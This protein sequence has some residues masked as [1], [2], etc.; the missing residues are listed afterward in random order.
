MVSWHKSYRIEKGIDLFPEGKVP[1]E[2]N[3]NF[4]EYLSSIKQKTAVE[5][6]EE[7]IQ[8]YLNVHY[9]GKSLKDISY[10]KQIIRKPSSIIPSILPVGFSQRTTTSAVVPEDYRQWVIFG[11]SNSIF[12]EVIMNDVKLYLAE[13]SGRRLCLDFIPASDADA[14]II[15]NYGNISKTPDKAAQIKPVLKLDG[16][17]IVQGKS[18]YTGET[19]FFGNIL[20]GKVCKAGTYVQ[21]TC[22]PVSASEITIQKAKEELKNISTDVIL[23]DSIREEYLGR[24]G[25]ILT[26]T[27]LLREYEIAKR[28]TEL[29]HCEP[30]YGSPS[31]A[32]IYI[33]SDYEKIDTEAKF[34]L[35]PNWTLDVYCNDSS[36]RKLENGI[37][38][39]NDNSNFTIGTFFYK[40]YMHDTSWNEGC[41]FEDWQDTPGAST[42]KGIMIAKEQGIPV[43]TLTKNDIV[44]GHLSILENETQ[45]RLDDSSIQTIIRELNNDRT[46]TVPIRKIRYEDMVFS[47]YRYVGYIGGWAMMFYQDHGGANSGLVPLNNSTTPLT[48]NIPL[49]QTTQIVNNAGDANNPKTNDQAAVKPVDGDPV[50]LVT[51]EFYHEENPDF[52]IKSRGGL[53]LDIIRN[54]KSQLIYNGP[55]G[56]GWAWNHSERLLIGTNGD[57]IF[58]NAERIPYYL[59]ANPD[60]TYQ[61]P[62]GTTFVMKKEAGGYVLTEKDKRKIFFSEKG[63]LI[64]KEDPNGNSLTFEYDSQDQLIKI[65]DPAD[66]Y[67]S[68]QYN[69]SG[70]ISQISDFRGGSCFYDY[71]GDDLIRFTDLEGNSYSYEYLKSQESTPDR[72]L[73]SC[74]GANGS[75]NFIDK[76]GHSVIANGNAKIDTSQS[77]FGGSSVRFDGSGDYLS[78]SDSDDWDFG[79]GDFTIDCWVRPTSVTAGDFLIGNA[80]YSERSDGWLIGTDGGVGDGGRIAFYAMYS[81]GWKVSCIGVHGMS[82]NTWHH[83]AVVRNGTSVKIYVDGIQKANSIDNPV[84]SITKTSGNLQIGQSPSGNAYA[85]NGW[86]DEFRITKG[87]ARWTAPFTPPT[88]QDSFSLNQQI[89]EENPD[90]G[91]NLCKYIL[92]NGD[93][94]EIGYYKNDTVSFHRNKKGEVFNFQYSRLNGYAETWNE[95]GY[96]RKVFYNENHDVTRVTTR[97]KTVE[98]KTY[99]SQHNITSFT[100][101]N[102]WTTNFTYDANRNLTSKTNALGE[103]WRYEYH[104]V[105]NKPAKIIDP[106]D[107]Q[108]QFEYDSCGNLIKITDALGN[109]TT[110]TYD[111]Y[112][113]LI[114]L[115]D[116]KGF[117]QENIYDSLGLNL[118][119]AKDK[120]A[121]RATY[122]YDDAGNLIAETD[123]AYNTTAYEYNRYNQK[124]KITDALDNVTKFEYDSNRF[125]TKIIE[126]NYAVTQ[127]IY[128]TVRDMVTGAKI[129]KTIDPL[130]YEELY[131]YDKLGNIISKTDKN[132]NTTYFAYDEMNRLIETTDPFQN[133]LR[134]TYDGN[135]NLVSITD[136][137]ENTTTFTYDAANR[138]TSVIDPNENKTGF[139]YDKSGN[140]TKETNAL[141]VVTKYEYDKLNRLT[142]KI[143]GEGLSNAR[144]FSFEYNELGRLI[145][146]TDPLGNWTSFEYDPNGNKTKETVYDSAANKLS[147]TAYFYDSRSLLIKKIDPLGNIWQFEYD[148]L[149]RKTAEI[150]P[151]ENRI[152]YAYDKAGN[153]RAVKDQLENITAFSYNLRK[154]KITQT[155]ALGNTKQFYYDFNGNLISVTDEQGNTILYSYDSL[156]RKIAETDALDNT[157]TIDYDENS[158][159][160]RKTDA[161]G[162]SYRYEYDKNNLLVTKFYPLEYGTIF[163]YD[164]LNRLIK[165]FDSRGIPTFSE[166]DSFGQVIKITQAAGCFFEQATTNFEYDANGNKIKEINALGAVTT[167]EYDGRN[168]LIKK[169]LIGELGLENIVYDYEYDAKGQ[170]IKAINPIG[171]AT[172]F[173][174]DK[175]GRK[176]SET[177]PAGNTTISEYDK[178]G[179]LIFQISPEGNK[180]SY[181]Y[182]ALGHKTKTIIDGKENNFSYDTKGRLVKETNFNGIAATY[183]YDALSHLKTKI[184]AANTPDESKTNFNYDQNGNLKEIYLFKKISSVLTPVKI[185]SFDYD[186]LNRC[187]AEYDAK[188]SAKRF[189][190]DGNG[191]ITQITKRSGLVIN[192]SYDNLN[193]L[194]EVEVSD[195]AEQVFTY[196]KLSRMT[197]AV[198]Y[199]GT[200]ATNTVAFEYDCFNRVSAEVQNAKRVEKKYD[201]NSN[202]VKIIYPSARV[203]EKTFT[204]ENLI[205]DI[206]YRNARITSFQYNKD[207]Q[208]NQASLGNGITQTINYNEQSLENSRKYVSAGGTAIYAMTTE[209]DPDGNA[210]RENITQNNTQLIKNY[211]YDSLNRITSGNGV[212]ATVDT[213]QYDE[214]GNWVSTTQNGP[215]NDDINRLVNSDN[216]YTY[217]HPRRYIDYDA[218]GNLKNRRTDSIIGKQYV[219]DWANRL[220]EIWDI[221]EH[222][223]YPNLLK[224]SYTYDAL[225]R[226]VT[227]YQYMWGPYQTVS[228]IHDANQVIEEYVDSALARSYVYGGYIDNPLLM[229]SSV[230]KY[231]YLNDRQYNV[232]FLTDENGIPV[233]NYEYNAFGLIKVFKPNDPFKDASYWLSLL[234]NPYSFTGRYYD[235][236]VGLYYYRNR[237]YSPELGRFLQ[238]DPQGYVDGVNLYAYVR[239]NPLRYLDPFGWSA[240]QKQSCWS[241]LTD[242]F[243]DAFTID[244]TSDSLLPDNTIETWKNENA[245]A[246]SS[247]EKLTLATNLFL[248]VTDTVGDVITTGYDTYQ[249]I[250]SPTDANKLSVGIDVGVLALPFVSATVVKAG[251][252]VFSK[253]DELVESTKSL[254]RKELPDIQTESYKKAFEGEVRLRTFRRGEKIYRSP[255]S[256]ELVEYPGDWFNTRKTVTRSATESQSNI[257]KWGNPVEKLRTYEFNDDVTTYYGKVKGG[258]GY[259]AYFPDDVDPADVLNFTEEIK[260]KGN[261]P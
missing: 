193:R 113:N 209:Y 44:D 98:L 159:I 179:N 6:Y 78:I 124:T 63:L 214:A 48:S 25:Q 8:Q 28:L 188:S 260:L 116:A 24:I 224:S 86:L 47:V 42:V 51:G 194:T 155:D 240:R 1:E 146:T 233:E 144:V 111:A 110:S 208:I 189:V 257:K 190:Y 15:S 212:F 31:V 186:L 211:T 232:V 131:D 73:L 213:W 121:N 147:E 222:W 13:I 251:A 243:K 183:E 252:K 199:N 151:L 227:Q 96:Y 216:E 41:I 220:I 67:L 254:M 117:T 242:P 103:T 136:K 165:T 259:Q 139:E 106:K 200:R 248:M 236:M 74:D 244:Y 62:S 255:A 228:F 56:Y 30:W 91:H 229:E 105:F 20:M 123:P 230:G 69:A 143:V 50:N 206:W 160:V 174:Y 134:N 32:F 246:L 164:V 2:L 168:L 65:I 202:P 138:K 36:V 158:N 115:T 81:G 226:K 14:Q 132:E 9:P 238:R 182:D 71:D 122:R 125:L 64:K 135:G 204:P 57:L 12:G 166:Y 104:P 77:K 85:F 68:F 27:F 205:K 23:N 52:D 102:G 195:R 231:Y 93:Y 142:R 126:P 100:D 60:G 112:G 46:V 201:L 250:K 49:S 84:T 241:P 128:D 130:G 196:D 17:I 245:P 184:E 79:A 172:M 150:D 198:D 119:E 140:L 219:Y 185:A 40:F 18:V 181:E 108:I 22:C 261:L 101:A 173:G 223:G 43:V 107:N 95:E 45:D 258:K 169:T 61:Y 129:A 191:N 177:N 66:R 89:L 133:T 176:V 161:L 154:E 16:K 38:Y 192:K 218:D 170:L 256:D 210:M 197:K 80:D 34:L 118:I 171:N 152:E 148:K 120:N 187:S 88:Q 70:K 249:L 163:Q 247:K 180:I 11:C 234:G 162:S 109:I 39:Q 90:N 239:N 94:L 207:S 235:A 149:K 7:K 137:R 82:V 253:G 37:F 167:Y 21:I 83:I 145:K 221:Y 99:D 54:Y 33:S 156:N 35:H 237:I 87:I 58:Y 72:L 153:L 127:N 3:F 75:T 19:V 76:I 5:L 203:V 178:T 4:D 53:K 217:I 59:T 55:F 215:Y 157:I 26:T 92:P 10:R 225:N 141:G 97:E 29:L 175:L 114:K